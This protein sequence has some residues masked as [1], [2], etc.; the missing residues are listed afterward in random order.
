MQTSFVRALI[1]ALA[2]ATGD[3]ASAPTAKLNVK[4]ANVGSG[5]KI[6]SL[7][8]DV[9]VESRVNDNI[10]VGVNVANGE[11]PLR[12]VFGKFNQKSGNGNIG[13]DASFSTADSAVSGEVSYAEGENTVAARVNSQNDQVV[14]SVKYTRKG[15]G[16]SFAPTFNMKEKNVDLEA[17]TDYSENTNVRVNMNHDGSAKVKVNHKFDADTAVTLT[18]TGPDVNALSVEVSRRLDGSNT[19][20]PKFDVGTKHASVGWV[21][22]LDAGR[23]VTLNVDPERTVGVDFEAGEND[24]KASVNAPWGDFKDADVS[25]GRKFNF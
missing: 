19:I 18:G 3:A 25:V 8:G 13:V 15:A 12:S 1:L 22:K 9:E 2:L 5:L 23:S 20:K 4:A 11:N 7:Q 6:G 16:W 17:S 14:D 21:R 24:W 10:S